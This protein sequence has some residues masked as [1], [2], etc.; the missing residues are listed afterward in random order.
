MLLFRYFWAVSLIWI[1][2]VCSCS[3]R[4]HGVAVGAV[5]SSQSESAGSS[6]QI[7]QFK[8]LFSALDIDWTI[9]PAAPT[10][11]MIFLLVFLQQDSRISSLWLR[12][13][14]LFL[15]FLNFIIWGWDWSHFLPHEFMFSLLGCLL[16]WFT[17]KLQSV[18]KESLKIQRQHFVLID[19]K[20]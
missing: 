3:S 2:P 14:S 4:P 11:L 10:Q 16:I 9:N 20:I 8:S 6:R 13:H 19:N 12:F 15:L 18:W 17:D 1:R 7:V 5:M